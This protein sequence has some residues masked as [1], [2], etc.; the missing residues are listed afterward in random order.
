MEEQSQNNSASSKF[1]KT[2]DGKTKFNAIEL[3]VISLPKG[4]VD[5][6]KY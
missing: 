3:L 2:D 5:T 6:P 1:L 4:S